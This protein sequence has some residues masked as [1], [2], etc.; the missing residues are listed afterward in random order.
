M[1]API[2]IGAVIRQ[3]IHDDGRTVSW[4]AD[5]IC[6]SRANVYKIFEKE[7]IDTNLLIRISKV[8]NYNFFDILSETL[9]VDR[10]VK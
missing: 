1:D 3:K 6:C 8:L 5:K 2:K 10:N 4:F 9:K 7:S